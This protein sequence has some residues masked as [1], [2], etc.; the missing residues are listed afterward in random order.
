MAPAAYPRPLRMRRPPR[1]SRRR[2][3]LA[4]LLAGCGGASA[5]SATRRRRS[6]ATLLLDFTPN[7]VHAGIY[8][9]L[10]AASTTARRASTCTCSRPVGLDRRRP[11]AARP[12]GRTSR[13]STSTTS[14]SRASAARTSSASWPSSQRPLAAVIAAARLRSPRHLEGQPVG[15]TGAA[16][17]R[18]GAA[19]RSSRGDGGDPAKVKPITIGFNAVAPLLAG[20]VAGATAFWNVEGVDAAA[21]SGPGFHV[22]RVDDYGAP[23]LSRARAVRHRR[24]R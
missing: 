16:Q 19:T 5:G 3:L 8:A 12:A 23:S 18:R 7:A 15:V 4:A 11:A 13:S 10:R 14:R 6:D 17:R 1:P 24:E 20:R 22:F 21:A 9:A 2:S